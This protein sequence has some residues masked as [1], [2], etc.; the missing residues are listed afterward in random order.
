[1]IYSINLKVRQGS[2]VAI[3][4]SVSAGKS[5]ILAALLGEM[6]KIDGQ[7]TISG[8]IAYVP[9]TAWILNATLKQNIL[10]GKDYDEKLYN[11]I[12]DACELRSDFGMIKFTSL[13]LFLL[14]TV[15]WILEHLPERDEIE[16]GEKGINLSGGQKQ[17]VALARA[18]YSDAD[19]YLFDDPLSAVDAHVGAHIFKYVIGPNGLLKNKTRILVTHGVSYLHKCDKIVVVAS[20]EIIDHGSYDELM[21]K[22]KT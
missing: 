10:F 13:A 4:G 6:C 19:I 20:G 11:E 1:C 16:I 22:S 12:I 2:L 21:K 17:R 18:L 15:V 5:S 3:V 8:T 7:V 9:Q 14:I